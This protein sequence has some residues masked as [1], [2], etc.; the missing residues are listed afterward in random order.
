MFSQHSNLARF[1]EV[2]QQSPERMVDVGVNDEYFRSA[3]LN[4]FTDFNISVVLRTGGE[5][6]LVRVGKTPT[7]LL[8]RAPQH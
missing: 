7:K 1:R 5:K 6:D 2:S 3:M 8:N 4:Y